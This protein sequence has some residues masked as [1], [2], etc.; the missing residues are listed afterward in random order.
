MNIWFVAMVIA[1][2]LKK[3]RIC[4]LCNSRLQWRYIHTISSD[5][6][7][8]IFLEEYA[9]AT[10]REEFSLISD[11]F[12]LPGPTGTQSILGWSV[13]PVPSTSI[14]LYRRV[15]KNTHR[16]ETNALCIQNIPKYAPNANRNR[17][18]RA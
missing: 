10:E 7:Y 4:S 18:L 2:S 15:I 8:V 13:L 16:G 11:I 12:N 17:L 6:K 9:A 14:C 3:N 1:L 5:K